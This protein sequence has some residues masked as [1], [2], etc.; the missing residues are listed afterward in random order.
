MNFNFPLVNVE[1]AAY[2]HVDE[3]FEFLSGGFQMHIQEFCC[4]SSLHQTT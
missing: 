1:K 3:V 2:L 4:S